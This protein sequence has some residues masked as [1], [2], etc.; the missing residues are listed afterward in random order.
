MLSLL[1]VAMLVCPGR[2]YLHATTSSIALALQAITIAIAT[3]VAVDVAGI[4]Q[5]SGT[6]MH[7]LCFW[8]CSHLLSLVLAC[9]CLL[10][11]A[12]LLLLPA[13]ACILWLACYA[14]CLLSYY[15]STSQAML[16]LLLALA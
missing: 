1:V 15:G 14:Y 12:C 2:C 10:A 7:A 3:A 4:F 9:Y 13:M 5:L 11:T 8:C 16:L 6:V